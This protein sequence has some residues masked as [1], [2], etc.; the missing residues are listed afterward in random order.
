M[1][2]LSFAL[3]DDDVPE[4]LPLEIFHISSLNSFDKFFL[5][6]GESVELILPVDEA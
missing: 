6:R 1:V 3:V 4:L 5:F 2:S